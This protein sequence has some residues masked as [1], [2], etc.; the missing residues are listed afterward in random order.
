[1]DITNNLDD[2]QYSKTQLSTYVIDLSNYTLVQ[3]L[4]Q[5]QSTFVPPIIK[6][7]RVTYKLYKYSYL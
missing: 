2:K 3:L 5:I 4:D 1:M 7:V 6:I